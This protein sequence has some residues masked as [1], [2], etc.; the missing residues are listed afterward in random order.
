MW[1]VMRKAGGQKNRR[2]VWAP[3]DAQQPVISGQDD[4]CLRSDMK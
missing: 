2:P 4:G 3:N 1:K